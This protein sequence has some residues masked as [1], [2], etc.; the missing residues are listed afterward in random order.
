MPKK[1]RFSIIGTSEIAPKH[2]RGIQ[3]NPKAQV[4]YIYSRDIKR[5]EEFARRYHLSPAKTY[6]EILSDRTI[7]A[8]DIVTEPARHTEL[9][10][11]AV[12]NKKHVLIE[13]PLDIDIEP[14]KKLVTLA[15][16]CQTVISVISQKR[17]DL[18]IMAM[19]GQLENKIIGK[20]FIAEA[21]VLLSRSHAYYS[22]CNG[23]RAKEGNVLINQAIHWIDIAIW[24]F[25]M[26]TK[27]KSLTSTVKPQISC[28]DT[29]ICCLEFPNGVLFNLVCSTALNKSQREE[30]R[31]Y[32][33]KGILDYNIPKGSRL[34]KIFNI[35]NKTSSF[36]RP[37][38]TPLEC[39]I[40]DFI[41]SIIEKRPPVVTLQDAYNALEIAKS[42]EGEKSSRSI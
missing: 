1:I 29:A 38:R 20:P 3:N 2:I 23:W 19:K 16:D 37:Y 28:F 13:K 15:S 22:K 9:A 34:S 14:A 24:F 5:S 42:C 11:E 10:L 26:P 41:N 7:D 8:V 12:K 31:I 39:Q 6:E 36:K 40:D 18:K 33:T 30:F 27:I 25:G 21:R 35:L 32:G 17:F 4:V